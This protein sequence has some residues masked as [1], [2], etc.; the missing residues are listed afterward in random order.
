MK[1]CLT[2]GAN[3]TLEVHGNLLTYSVQLPEGKTIPEN[4]AEDLETFLHT[5]ISKKLRYTSSLSPRWVKVLNVLADNWLHV[6]DWWVRCVGLVT[7]LV[8]GLVTGMMDSADE[9]LTIS[10]WFFLLYFVILLLGPVLWFVQARLP[11]V[12]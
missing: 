9:V 8:L 6:I 5:E 3:Y 4:L 7:W 2:P 1:K 10:A 11:K 12:K